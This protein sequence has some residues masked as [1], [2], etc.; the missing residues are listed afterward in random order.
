MEIK[1]EKHRDQLNKRRAQ[2]AMSLRRIEKE[3]NKSQ[4]SPDWLDRATHESSIALLDRLYEFYLT[5]VKNL[6]EALERLDKSTYGRCLACH[7]AIEP[8]RLEVFPET[9]F[10]SACQEVREGLQSV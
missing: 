1:A 7:Q 8:Q 10:C 2:C 6:D 3:R 9:T 5:E 4:V